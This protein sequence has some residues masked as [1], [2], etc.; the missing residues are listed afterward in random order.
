VLGDKDGDKGQAMR[1]GGGAEGGE[2]EIRG[3]KG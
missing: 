1:K 2:G 3:A